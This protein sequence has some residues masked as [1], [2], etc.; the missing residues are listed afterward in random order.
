[1]LHLFTSEEAERYVLE[2]ED[3]YNGLIQPELR[4]VVLESCFYALIR[5]GD[6]SRW[7]EQLRIEGEANWDP[8]IGFYDLAST[9]R[10][11]SGFPHN[12]L[13][14]VAAAKKDTLRVI[15]H[16]YRALTAKDPHPTAE[17][18]LDLEFKK[19]MFSPIPRP[20]TSGY[21]PGEPKQI[22]ENLI[23]W[24]AHL[25]GKCRQPGVLSEVQELEHRVIGY[26]TVN[27]KDLFMPWILMQICLINHLAEYAACQQAKGKVL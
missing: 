6:L 13:A 19:I 23:R 11:E 21:L 24:F 20:A 5:L 3:K 15:L 8:A 1:M 26:L 9:I 27:T 17:K 10:P 7:R 2:L 16:F 12:Q 18:N 4:P 22:L 25:H 14:V